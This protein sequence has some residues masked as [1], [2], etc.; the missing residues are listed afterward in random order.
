MPALTPE[1]AARA[2]HA[3]L[4]G[5]RPQVE[6]A[7]FAR[8]RAIEDAAGAGGRGYA[9]GLRPAV[10]AGLEYGLRSIELARDD[11]VP[12]VPPMLLVQARLAAREGVSLDTVLRRYCGANTLFF[13]VLIEEAERAA[14]SQG[15]LKRFYRTWS[16]SFEHLLAVVSEEY[17]RE[18]RSR[19]ESEQ[20]RLELTERLLAGELL[21]A[22]ELSYG[23]DCW[24]LGLLA[25]GAGAAEALRS[26]ASALDRAL[27]L[28]D[29][30]AETVW[31]WLGGRRAF[32]VP[33]CRE[34]FANFPWPATVSIALGEPA[35]GLAGWRLSHRQA[36]AT[37]Q[38]ALRSSEPVL[39]YSQMP[40][41]ASTLQDDLLASSLDQLYLAPLRSERDGGEAA[42]ETLRAYFAAAGNVSSAASA[43]GVAR[44]TVRSRIA[45]IEEKIGRPVD[46]VS[47]EI[48]TALRLDEIEPHADAP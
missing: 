19:P 36:A 47:A 24:H 44:N 39:W 27:L 16:S 48:E 11:R 25:T 31:A 7:I 32:D 9:Q 37:L 34:C 4:I 41:L 2:L 6:E 3:R 21:D 13:D 20:R 40:L 17:A 26:F 33:E 1:Q 28:V 35:E 45:A 5:R 42:K 14:L 43:L 15:E 10:S 38:V 22:S 12:E 30:D 8:V 23:F 18:D 46:S 29:R